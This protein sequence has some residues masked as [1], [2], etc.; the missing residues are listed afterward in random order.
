MTASKAPTW[1]GTKAY[2][3]QRNSGALLKQTQRL[4][5][6]CLV[7]YCKMD[8]GNVGRPIGAKGDGMLNL[9]NAQERCLRQAVALKAIVELLLILQTW[10][11]HRA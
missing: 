2:M 1:E 7:I 5:L 6:A 9:S 11:E 3:Q 8:D 4:L 10:T